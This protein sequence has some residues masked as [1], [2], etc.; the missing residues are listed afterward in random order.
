MAENEI[1]YD[2]LM[3]K[4]LKHVVIEALKYASEK[5]KDFLLL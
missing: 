3:E 2:I 1:N 5:I 4:A